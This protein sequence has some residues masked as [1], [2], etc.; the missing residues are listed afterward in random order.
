[1]QAHGPGRRRRTWRNLAWIS[2]KISPH[3]PSHCKNNVESKCSACHPPFGYIKPRS[4]HHDIP[5]LTALSAQRSSVCEAAAPPRAFPVYAHA[6]VWSEKTREVSSH[7]RFPTFCKSVGNPPTAAVDYGSISRCSLPETTHPHRAT[8]ADQK[9]NSKHLISRCCSLGRLKLVDTPTGL[10]V[11]T[12]K[13]GRTVQ[14][15]CRGRP[16][17]PADVSLSRLVRTLTSRGARLTRLI[18]PQ[19]PW[20]V[21][22]HYCCCVYH[23][24]VDEV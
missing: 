20:P 19:G 16:C 15:A 23:W 1:M 17:T 24:R 10:I 5:T 7:I 3:P 13:M 2:D 6:R 21:A 12:S 8:P 4:C 18:S 11:P 9:E 22:H 14:V